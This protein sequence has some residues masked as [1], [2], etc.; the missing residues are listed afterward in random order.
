[1][2]ERIQLRRGLAATWTTV[3]PVLAQGEIGLELDT[4]KF[5]WG[6]GVVAWNSLSYFGGGISIGDVTGLAAALAGKVDD[7]QITAFMLT[8]LDDPD[9]ATARATL[10]LGNVNNTSDANKPVSTATQA[11][12]DLKSNT[13]NPTFTGT[14]TGITKAMVGLG[15]VDNT[16][17]ADKPVSTATQTALNAKLDDSQ[18]TAFGLSLLDDAD[19]TAGRATLGLGTAAT[20]ASTDYTPAAHA[21]AG[22][23]AHAVATGATAGFMSATDKTKLDTLANY[24]SFKGVFADLAALQ[25]AIPTGVTG[26]WAHISNPSG[27]AHIAVW[28]TDSASWDEVGET[29]AA[30]GTDISITRTGTS[31]TVVSSTG[32]DGTIPAADAAN[33]GVM[34]ATDKVKLDGVATGA[35][36]NA[37][38]AALRDRATHTG[39]Q[40][41]ATISDFAA[42]VRATVLTGIS[43]ATN[44]AVVATDTVLAAVGKLQA[45]ITGHFGVGGA[46]HPDVVAAGASGFM[47]GADKTKLNGIA[48]GATA[49]SS[50]AVLLARANHTGTQSLATISDVTMTAANLNTLDDGVSTALHFHASDRDRANHTGTQTAA[51]ISDFSAAADAR[52]GAASINALADVIVTAASTGQVLKFNG[53][54]WINDTDATGGGGVTDGDKG[55]ITVT[56][57]GATWTIDPG[58]VTLAKQA[59]LAANS[60]IGNNTGAGATPIA[61]T[62]AQ[63]KAMLA[64]ASADVSG[65]GAL[66]TAS[67]VNLTTQ[68]T[69]ALQAAQ[70]PAQTGDVTN[71]AGSL[72]TTIANGVVTLPKMANLATNSIIGNNTGAGAAPIALTTAQATAMFDVFTALLKG[73]VPASGGGTAN[74]LRADGTWS[75]PAGGGGSLSVSDEGVLLTAA[76]ASMNFVGAGVTATTV[77]GAVT[78]TIAGGSGGSGIT[79]G[80]AIA[81]NTGN[82]IP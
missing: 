49:N 81:L 65:L 78:V 82:Y 43:F 1:M 30:P 3:N 14:V 13:N 2:A 37:T 57:T 80:K 51:T 25:T 46:T 38:D 17:D 50:D 44:A 52:I 45:Q 5:K 32:A 9:A 27:A 41:A 67:T 18:A 71:T 74:F 34:L 4:Y 68:A 40:L 8:L 23:A 19:A 73:L 28:A 76:A 77:G 58:T 21:G 11:A 48:T 79:I 53:T 16:S 59:N 54:N 75:A 33:A 6:D 31:V 35:T 61:L 69:G 55:D 29:V 60:I 66:A 24:T 72:A 15:A 42:A 47:S 70:F 62:P 26:D 12:L 63:V 56:A 39:S 20:T 22:G 10:E 36:A 7:S 64:I